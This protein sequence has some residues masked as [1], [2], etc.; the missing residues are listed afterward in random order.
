MAR[1]NS[2][3]KAQ[4]ARF[5][6]EVE[7]LGRAE[8]SVVVGTTLADAWARARADWPSID[9][10]HDHGDEACVLEVD[11]QAVMLL[12]AAPP[13]VTVAHESLH[14]VAWVMR[15]RG[16]PFTGDNEEIVAY[17]LEW[18]LGRVWPAASGWTPPAVRVTCPDRAP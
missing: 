18:V 14:V 3:R 16:I 8:F 17:A 13:L 15:S 2:G 10:S 12:A 11:D 6:F 9:K 1:G 7:L 4:S 5:D